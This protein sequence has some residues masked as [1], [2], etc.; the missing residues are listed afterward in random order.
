[1]SGSRVRLPPSPASATRLFSTVSGA[2]ERTLRPNRL[3]RTAP[4][5]GKARDRSNSASPIASARTGRRTRARPPSVKERVRLMIPE[6][7]PSARSTIPSPPDRDRVTSPVGPSTWVRSTAIRDMSPGAKKSGRLTAM[8]TGSRTTISASPSPT[9]VFDQAIAISLSVP[10]KSG[11]SR[12]TRAL[13]SGLSV[14]TPEN[15]L[16]R[17]SIGGGLS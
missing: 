13:P 9:P 14:T 10:L 3:V 16:T 5:S 15:R 1:M 8:T 2:L 11:M 6:S 7:V 17:S 4:P 12:S